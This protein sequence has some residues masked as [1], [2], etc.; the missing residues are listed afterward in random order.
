MASPPA[1]LLML[2]PIS[3]VIGTT[4]VK[5]YGGGVSSTLLNRNGMFVGAALLLGAALALERE[6]GVSWTTPAIASVLY[7]AIMGTVVTF[8]LFFWLLRYAP[9]HR[10][11]L[12][13]Y[14]TPAIALFLGW[15]FRR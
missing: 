4:L 6:A 1:L 11:A 9:A 13:A 12:I 15:A 2:S 5:R 7:L 10:M 8:S 14:V 3:V